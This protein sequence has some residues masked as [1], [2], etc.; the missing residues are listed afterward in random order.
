[1]VAYKADPKTLWKAVETDEHYWSVNASPEHPAAPDLTAKIARAGLHGRARE[2]NFI[3][4]SWE[5]AEIHH[6]YKGERIINAG[7]SEF[8]VGE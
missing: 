8:G 2:R 7:Q 6:W 4:K 3:F 5:D 1:M